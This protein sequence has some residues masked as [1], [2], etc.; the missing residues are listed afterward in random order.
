MLD[1]WQSQLKANIALTTTELEIFDGLGNEPAEQLN[2][3][4]SRKMLEL[5]MTLQGLKHNQDSYYKFDF[6]FWW[7]S[8]FYKLSKLGI[9]QS[10]WVFFT[11]LFDKQTLLILLVTVVGIG[12]RV[13]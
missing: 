11:H 7:F 10:T 2:E 5:Q 4:L 9:T 1:K 13:A 12:W 8:R 6:D 3:K